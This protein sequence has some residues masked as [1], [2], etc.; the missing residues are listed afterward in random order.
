[1]KKWPI[2]HYK[3]SRS[4]YTHVYDCY[5]IVR[6]LG[7]G[8]TCWFVSRIHLYIIFFANGHQ[9]NLL[10]CSNLFMEELVSERVKRINDAVVCDFGGTFTGP[11]TY[12]ICGGLQCVKCF[13]QHQLPDVMLLSLFSNSRE[14]KMRK[15]WQ[16][17][18]GQPKF[19]DFTAPFW[20]H[21]NLNSHFFFFF[22]LVIQ[23]FQNLT[24]SWKN[25]PKLRRWSPTCRR[26]PVVIQAQHREAPTARRRRGRRTLCSPC[27]PTHLRPSYP[28]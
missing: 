7:G 19:L 20:P 28:N 18:V 16:V 5:I 24:N 4:F 8:T 25:E 23:R 9:L 15:V 27:R 1:M 11:F 6:A 13:L 14:M 17:K 26:P 12:L 22:L 3:M 2:K 10:R 21:L